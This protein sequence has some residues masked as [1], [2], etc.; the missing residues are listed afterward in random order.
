MARPDA[1]QEPS[2]RPSG[3]FWIV[4]AAVDAVALAVLAFALWLGGDGDEAWHYW[5]APVLALQVVVLLGALAFGYYWKV[6]RLEMRGRP[7]SG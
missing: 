5:F 7:R 1:A 3:I 6:V 4:V 2:V